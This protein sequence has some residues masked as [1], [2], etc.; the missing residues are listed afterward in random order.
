MIAL[1]TNPIGQGIRRPCTPGILIAYVADTD[2]VGLVGRDL[3]E[4][5]VVMSESEDDDPGL[6]D[7][8]ALEYIEWIHDGD[9]DVVC[10]VRE[11]EALGRFS[12]FLRRRF[13]A[14]FSDGNQFGIGVGTL[15]R[16]R[17]SGTF[18]RVLACQ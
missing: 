8:V 17:R 12:E 9:P 14:R 16:L 15:K 4:A 7:R 2:T 1:R 5:L 3:A 10:L 6:I 11:P 18:A 13:I